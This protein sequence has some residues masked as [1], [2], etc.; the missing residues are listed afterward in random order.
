MILR[1]TIESLKD[2]AR[3]VKWDVHA[4]DLAS[5][6]PRLPWYAKAVGLVV[7]GYASVAD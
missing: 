1:P 4:L 2:W 7:A 5:R 6:D 3:I